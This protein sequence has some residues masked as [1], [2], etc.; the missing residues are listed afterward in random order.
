MPAARHIIDQTTESVKKMQEFDVKTLSRTHEFGAQMG[1]A[2]AAETAGH[3]VSLYQKIN[4]PTL[5]AMPQAV[6]DEIKTAADEGLQSFQHIR[7]F[8]VQQGPDVR[9]RI[10]ENVMRAY[11]VS[12][13]I[14]MQPI[15]FELSEKGY[16]KA[17][18]NDARKALRGVESTVSEKTKEV[19][20]KIEKDA[21]QTIEKIKK[22][23]QD[24]GA[25]MEKANEAASKAH[26]S[27][28]MVGVAQH[29]AI[30]H[31]EAKSCQKKANHWLI[32]AVIAVVFFVFVPGIGYNFLWEFFAEKSAAAGN[33]Q[34]YITRVVLFSA[35]VYALF[36]CVKNY[37]AT[38]HNYVVN[39]HRKNA[40]QTFQ[41]LVDSAKSPD[42]NDI[43]LT[44]AARCIF[45]QQ[46]TGYAKGGGSNEGGNVVNFSP[47][48]TAQ[49][50]IESAGKD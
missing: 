18:K 23:E 22:V 40:L 46:D 3:M 11:D 19:V 31:D 41:V 34:F 48:K 9:S 8:T 36:F 39:E 25:V 43:V 30:F 16:L 21:A 17:L 37:G 45:D 29:A 26:E 44:H 50:V 49:K 35:T 24:A 15:C 7:N 4:L 33:V 14:L 12:F 6:L 32:A 1:F 20:A 47:V 27:A 13:R 2:D 38:R 10:A 5:A 42:A 28:S